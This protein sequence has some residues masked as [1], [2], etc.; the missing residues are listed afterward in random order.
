MMMYMAAPLG[1]R[2]KDAGL[3]E[4]RDDEGRA[5]CASCSLAL[6]DGAQLRARDCNGPL[7]D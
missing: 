4:A 1:Q 2:E 3:R 6:Q 5:T 7:H